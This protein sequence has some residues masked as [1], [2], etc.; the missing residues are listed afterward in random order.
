MCVLYFESHAWTSFNH[1]ISARYCFP[2]AQTQ[3]TPL[4]ALVFIT[5]I[6]GTQP[7]NSSPVR[8]CLLFSLWPWT[9]YLIFLNDV[10]HHYNALHD[11]T[12]LIGGAV[13]KYYRVQ[14]PEPGWGWAGQGAGWHQSG[15]QR[16][17]EPVCCSWY[18]KNYP[19][20]IVWTGEKTSSFNTGHELCS[21]VRNSKW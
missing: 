11:I 20:K 14:T 2:L 8:L 10:F 16:G 7:L 1:L 18:Y 17:R 5:F 21:F 6:T 13:T 4:R 9:L 12:R 19:W 3:E 15:A